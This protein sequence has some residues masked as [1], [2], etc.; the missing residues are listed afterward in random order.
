MISKI[1]S[2]E[3]NSIRHEYST[4]TTAFKTLE[5]FARLIIDN[6]IFYHK[7]FYSAEP[8]L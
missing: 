1:S 6:Y 7:T 2:Q 8:K 5:N 3:I 4:V